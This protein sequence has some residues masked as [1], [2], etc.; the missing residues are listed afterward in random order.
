MEDQ[1]TSMIRV[2]A[3]PGVPFFLPCSS[4]LRALLQHFGEERLA[5][6]WHVPVHGY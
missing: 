4:P 2:S 1:S 6:E 3:H 5:L